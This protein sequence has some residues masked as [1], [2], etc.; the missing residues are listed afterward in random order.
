MKNKLLTLSL[1]SCVL[2]TG[3]GHKHVF[4]EATCTTASTCDCGEVQGEALGHSWLDATYEAPKTCEICG[5]TEGE[6]LETEEVVDNTVEDVIEDTIVDEYETTGIYDSLD[7]NKNMTENADGTYSY[8]DEFI[9]AISGYSYFDGATE[10][11]I[12]DFLDFNAPIL[13]G[14][15]GKEMDEMMQDM[16][17]N[18]HQEHID[19]G[20]ITD[21]TQKPS[22]PSN[23]GGSN[24]GGGNDTNG[25]GG[26][27]PVAT[28]STNQDNV[29]EEDFI[30]PEVSGGSSYSDPRPGETTLKPM[31][32]GDGGE[33]ITDIQLN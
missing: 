22:T 29:K 20:L 30:T 1:L 6:K 19:K 23:Q 26:S 15:D 32:L 21:D 25:G 24:N 12:T 10:K 16:E 14:F 8:S 17:G 7:T 4:S 28:P 5:L 27:A 2:L 3:C 13:Y 31:D 33:L 11:E 18:L 9:N